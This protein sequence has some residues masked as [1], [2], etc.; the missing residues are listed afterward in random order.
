MNGDTQAP[1]TR[2]T[3]LLLTTLVVSAGMLLLLAG[4]R[5]PEKVSPPA[6]PATPAPPLERLAARATYAELARVLAGL[7]SQIAPRLVTL[8]RHAPADGAGPIQ[9][10]AI[11]ISDTRALALV[12]STLEA[13]AFDRSPE[14]QGIIA[15][16]EPRGLALVSVAPGSMTGVSSGD[17]PAGPG[18]AVAVDAGP[19]G[20]GVRPF[21]Y[22][23]VDR[24][25]AAGWDQPVLRFSALQHVP[26]AGSAIFLLDGSFVGLGTAEADAFV[27]V[28]DALLQGA[29]ARLQA[30]G[31]IAVVDIGADVAPLT[32]ELQAALSADSGVV[33]THVRNDGPAAGVLETFDVLQGIDGRDIRSIDDFRAAMTRLRPGQPFP[34]ALRRRAEPLSVTLDPSTNQARTEHGPRPLGLDLRALSGVGS[35][36]VRVVPRSAAARAG[37][38]PGDVITMIDGVKAPSPAAIERA[39]RGLD[40]ERL[41]LAVQ[42]G[43]RHLLVVLST[44]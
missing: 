38:V 25:T 11:R 31:T 21:Y 7:Q 10:P 20:P 30:E 28:P 9:V 22:G 6:I 41:V 1:G 12:G 14:V 16:D 32:S 23:R 26:P 27:V 33:V 36:V 17:V 44:S 4:F 43:S 15:L 35:E 39:F 5:F 37:V 24:V 19:N 29:A 42:R 40:R 2:D 3:R 18:Y 8:R 34:L 13:D